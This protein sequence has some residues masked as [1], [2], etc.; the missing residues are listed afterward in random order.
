MVALSFVSVF[1]IAPVQAAT[2]LGL[3]GLASGGAYNRGSYTVTL[4]TSSSPD[5]VIAF[6]TTYV[7]SSSITVSSISS[8]HLVFTMRDLVSN[9]GNENLEEW[10]AI[11][12][13][14]LTSE[15]I[16]VTLSASGYSTVSIFGISGANTAPPFDNHAGLPASSKVN[17]GTTPR[18][19]GIS[20][21]NA[22]DMILS[23]Y[24][25]KGRSVPW[26]VEPVLQQ[27]SGRHSPGAWD[28]VRS[29]LL[30]PVLGDCRL[31]E[32]RQLRSHYRRCSSG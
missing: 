27:S 18:I 8:A 7:G 20:T 16:T 15:T 17:S 2:S 26:L 1:E 23:S 5:V 19:A 24:G 32:Q 28:R 13:S 30:C 21:S 6:V 11:S 22:N 25:T 12:A 29:G 9:T 4:S 31:D 3:D 10:Y 14:A